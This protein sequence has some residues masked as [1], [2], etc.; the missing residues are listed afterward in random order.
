MFIF[1]IFSL[2]VLIL[3]N[4]TGCS[5]SESDDIFSEQY[6]YDYPKYLDSAWVNRLIY[7]ISEK[8]SFE[9]SDVAPL[10]FSLFTHPS[11]QLSTHDTDDKGRYIVIAPWSLPEETDATMSVSFIRQWE[12]TEL[13]EL[14]NLISNSFMPHLTEKELQAI[15]KL[16]EVKVDQGNTD[17]YLIERNSR[18]L[19]LT[20][21]GQEHWNS[22]L[23]NI[24]VEFVDLEE[25]GYPPLLLRETEEGR[26]ELKYNAS[27]EDFINSDDAFSDKYFDLELEIYEVNNFENG[28][29]IIGIVE[30]NPANLIS[31]EI[32][33][34][35]EQ[36]K[37][38]DKIKVFAVSKGF[39][40]RDGL[41]PSFIGIEIFKEGIPLKLLPPDF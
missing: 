26:E 18:R 5:F 41:I 34:T 38:K 32:P 36:L 23:L 6:A 29:V 14:T 37:V 31:V 1:K 27:Y 40:Y 33:Q 25:T 35:A 4:L 15:K 11:V 19:I 8:S 12:N 2:I 28:I 17:S 10:H 3:F 39:E 21:Y 22:A 9:I 16:V 24:K 20:K 30:N 13:L 7:I